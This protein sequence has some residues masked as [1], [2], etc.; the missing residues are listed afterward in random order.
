MEPRWII[1]PE[2]GYQLAER[3]TY[4]VL[5]KR[6][7]LFQ[8]FLHRRL[9]GPVDANQSVDE[10]E[11]DEEEPSEEEPSEEEPSEE[12]FEM[13][14]NKWLQPK[15]PS[16]VSAPRQDNGQST[17]QDN[18]ILLDPGTPLHPCQMVDTPTVPTDINVNYQ[19]WPSDDDMHLIQPLLS[20]QLKDLNLEAD[21]TRFFDLSS[22]SSPPISTY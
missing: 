4:S 7:A 6:W 8:S 16:T 3:F 17:A 15:L 14:A 13:V 9:R 10:E 20:A 18:S 5:A 1:S 12:E 21:F 2:G 11:L 22:F 19:I